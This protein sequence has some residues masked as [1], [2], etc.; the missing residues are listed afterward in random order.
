MT[1]FIIGYVGKLIDE[2]S[3]G[4]SQNTTRH[5]LTDFEGNRIGTINL[6]KSWPIRNG[7]KSDRMWQAYAHIKGVEYTG[8]TMGRCMA[9]RGVKTAAQ[10]RKENAKA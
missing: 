6:Y 9:F 5:E 4:L 1:H 2:K 10:K 7:W 3:V 8:R